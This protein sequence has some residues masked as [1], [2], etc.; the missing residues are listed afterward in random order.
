MNRAVNQPISPV[1]REEENVLIDEYRREGYKRQAM[2]HMVYHPPYQICPWPNCGF[3][4]ASIDFQVEKLTDPNLKRELLAAWWQGPGM[5]GRC[6]G[7]GNFVL[8]SMDDKKAVEHPE[9]KGLKIL[10]EDWYQNAFI[11]D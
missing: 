4:I 9:S 5:V 10:P 8:F 3:R 2:P 11:P 6:P 1:S 7:C